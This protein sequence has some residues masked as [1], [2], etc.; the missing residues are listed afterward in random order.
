M[1]NYIWVNPLD[2]QVN[3]GSLTSATK[4][5]Y[6]YLWSFLLRWRDHLS[7]DLRSLALFRI[8]LGLLLIAD[9]VQRS[10]D[11]A[12][13]Y[14]DAGILPRSVLL[15]QSFNNRPYFCL[16]L[17]GGSALFQ[18]A[19]FIIAGAFALALTLGYRTRL[20]TFV[21]WLLL[22]SLHNRNY[23][24]LSAGDTVLRQ[25]LFWSW[26]LPLGAHFS[27]DRASILAHSLAS[28]SL[29]HSP[30]G[31]EGEE[32]SQV[33]GDSQL[34]TNWKGVPPLICSWGTVGFI[35]QL[36][37]IYFFSALLKSG[38]V[39]TQDYTAVYYSL[40][41]E[42]FAKQP[43]YWLLG[44]PDLL[45]TI[46]LVVLRFELWGPVLVLLTSARTWPRTF[47]VLAFMGFHI[48]LNLCLDI[49][50]FAVTCSLMWVALLPSAFWGWLARCR[51]FRRR[52]DIQIVYD[53]ECAFCR[54]ALSVLQVIVGVPTSCCIPAQSDPALLQEVQKQNSW[55]VIDAVG[56]RFYRFEAL[57][58]VLRLRPIWDYLRMLSSFPRC[59]RW[60]EAC[61]R[62]VA[63]RRVPASR[64]TAWMEGEKPQLNLSACSQAMAVFFLIYITLWN[65]RGVYPETYDQLLPKQWDGIAWSTRINQNWAMFRSPPQKDGWYVI[66]AQQ[67]NDREID[68]FADG[69]P[70]SWQKPPS[71][72][73]TYKNAHWRKYLEKL[74]SSSYKEH[75]L[76]YAR[77]VT[78]QW[79]N[80]HPPQEQV[81]TFQIYFMQERNL[82]DGTNSLPKK[83]LLWS[84]RCFPEPPKASPRQ[85]KRHT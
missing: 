82:L 45:K 77:Y 13:H 66:A 57:L 49:G 84:H 9:L 2:R 38:A 39:W 11:L 75:R 32:F 72:L 46:T 8:C 14:T 10:G 4:G 62:W 34:S 18:A 3:S 17:L 30:L 53:Q 69:A 31:G 80:S 76:P 1:S 15:E 79:N 23:L 67:R 22:I 56:N 12:A 54:R 78:R 27:L 59:N 20:M 71:I 41:L 83:I 58:A 36:G 44:Y 85:A 73:A 5:S 68:L 35:L 28:S 81:L 24:I 51:L 25:L 50:L 48:G 63:E 52:P 29:N 16:H 74:V 7:L 42:Q 33:K 6:G 26:F 55:I 70:L 64:L 19:L 60:G 37:Y 65:L 43:A 40:R 21:S 61:Y 47:L